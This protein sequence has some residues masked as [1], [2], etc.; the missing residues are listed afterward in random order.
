MIRAFIAFTVLSVLLA[1]TGAPDSPAASTAAAGQTRDGEQV[2]IG[3]FRQ[4]HSSVLDE[5][6]LLLVCLPTDYE[7]GAMSYP[8]LFV[9]YGGQIRGYFS[10]AVHVVDRL[11]EEGSIP[12]MIVVGLAN[13]DRYRD[14][15]PVGRR[16]NP[17]GIEPFSRFVADELIPFVDSDY[18][19]KDFRVLVGPQAGAEFGLYTLAA[20][21]GLFDAFI[22]ENPFRSGPVR[23]VL[24]REFGKV[25]DG[26][27]PSFTYL[28]VSCYERAGHMDMT[29]ET[30]MFRAFEKKVSEREPKNLTLVTHYVG[31]NE[32]F[33]PP[34]RIKEGLRELFREYRF[35]DNKEV[36]GLDDVT[37][38]Y[39]S[40][41]GRF[42]FEIDVPEMTLVTEAVDLKGR[43]DI[44]SARE[45]LD[46]LIEIYP[47]S[48]DGHWQLANLYRELGERGRAIEHYREC[49]AIIPGMRPAQ[50][51]LEKLEEER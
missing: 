11:S 48:V 5:D 46:Y 6:R 39:I 12:R 27:L 40:L 9:L 36:F 2:S 47:R 50:Y 42:G 17:S 18:R 4:L 38:H 7:A 35:P 20:R 25:M 23:D 26:G 16:G 10:K 37:E 31:N 44:E 33:I 8:V 19:T 13:V 43:G 22:I 24:T 51:W 15:S 45:I 29:A 34:L 30:E 28:Q 49:L 1:V 21:P 41:S 3:T 14:L 32:D